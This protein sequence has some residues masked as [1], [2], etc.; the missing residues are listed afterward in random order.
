MSSLNTHGSPSGGRVEPEQASFALWGGPLHMVRL[1]RRSIWLGSLI[2]LTAACS[3]GGADSNAQIL[4]KNEVSA[5]DAP[6]AA[7]C[8][9]MPPDF[10]SSREFANSHPAP[11]G[12]L[13]NLIKIRADRSITW[14]GDDGSKS[15]LNGPYAFLE[16][17]LRGVSEIYPVPL[18][19]L[20]FDP[21][22]PCPVINKVREMMREHLECGT[23]A[24]CLQ[25]DGPI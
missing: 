16:A 5:D 20:D 19:I 24:V 21:G 1:M 25:G 8:S 9:T 17:N 23:N 11:R 13:Q 4:A 22:T 15:P 6:S 18:T 7:N 10:H 12:Y 2:C 3:P 14:N